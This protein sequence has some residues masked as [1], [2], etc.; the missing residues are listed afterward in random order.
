MIACQASYTSCGAK[1]YQRIG[2]AFQFM[3]NRYKALLHFS[4]R[5]RILVIGAVLMLLGGCLMLI[6]LIGVDVELV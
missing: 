1:I 2:Q 5:H 3:E 4:L 6:P